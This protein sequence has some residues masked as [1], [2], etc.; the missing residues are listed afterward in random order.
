MFSVWF[1]VQY[2][3]DIY[4]VQCLVQYSVDIYNVQCLVQCSIHFFLYSVVLIMFIVQYSVDIYGAQCSKFFVLIFIVFNI[5][6]NVQYSVVINMTYLCLFSSNFH[7]L[8]YIIT[9]LKVFRNLTL[10]IVSHVVIKK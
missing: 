7:W 9:Y 2:S 1:N 5:W 6:L 8:L 3:V 10:F 4:N